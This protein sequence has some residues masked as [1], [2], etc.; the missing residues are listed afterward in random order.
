M[1]HLFV[2][3]IYFL[4][5]D[6]NYE[7]VTKCMV[8]NCVVRQT[9]QLAKIYIFNRSVYEFGVFCFQRGLHIKARS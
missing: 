8:S 6:E 7:F 1:T 4:T 2:G 3:L 9:R 5:D